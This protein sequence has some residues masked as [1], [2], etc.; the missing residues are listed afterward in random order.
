MPA[1]PLIPVVMM[2]DLDPG[3]KA[4]PVGPVG[5]DTLHVEIRCLGD[6]GP[7]GLLFSEAQPVH[8]VPAAGPR[9]QP[10]NPEA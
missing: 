5:R 4:G 9:G 3:A 8:A 10:S 2:T 1:W 6:H 7:A